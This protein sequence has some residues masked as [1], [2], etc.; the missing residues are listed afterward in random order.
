M[1]ISLSPIGYAT[2]TLLSLFIGIWEKMY[3]PNC[4]YGEFAIIKNQ[5]DLNSFKINYRL[6][7]Q[8]IL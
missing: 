8:E 4:S 7:R 3:N 1:V 2:G 5:A 6:R